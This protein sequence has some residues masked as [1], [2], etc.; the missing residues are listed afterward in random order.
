MSTPDAA[1]QG[2]IRLRMLKSKVIEA[3]DGPTL[4]ANLN[5]WYTNFDD[6]SG[7]RDDAVLL[8]IEPMEYGSTLAVLITYTE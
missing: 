6:V 4:Q 1:G 3:A 7:H 2:A 5:E 8:S